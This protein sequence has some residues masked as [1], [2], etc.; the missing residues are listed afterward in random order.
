MSRKKRQYEDVLDYY[1]DDNFISISSTVKE[2][3]W[4]SNTRHR[5]LLYKMTVNNILL[6][7]WKWNGKE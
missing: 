6:I 5:T 1:I 7:Y 2:D 4:S 3:Y